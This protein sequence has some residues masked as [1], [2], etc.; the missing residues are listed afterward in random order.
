MPSREPGR[1]AIFFD[2]GNTL[3]HLDYEGIAATFREYGVAVT[4]AQVRLGEQRARVPIDGM[5][6]GTGGAQ[7][8]ERDILRAYFRFALEAVG[9]PFTAA[10][11]A[12]VEPLA[13]RVRE[14]RL[15][16]VVEPGTDALLADLA[17][18]GH[19]LGVVSNSNGT[20]ES[21]LEQVGLRRH[22][23]FV[24]DSAVVG[25]EKPHPRIFHLALERGGV[26]AAEAVY[27][28]DLYHVDVL[29][30]TGAGLGAVLLD[31]AGAWD[32]VTCPKAPDLLAAAAL[33]LRGAC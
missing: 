12:A 14:G 5:V 16:T 31:P 8:Q 27:I 19:L 1:K 13:R 33:I 18:R 6:A 20:V 22:F 4:A 23:A 10:A 15:W 28:G 3:L 2:A 29:G 17:R 30:A 26:R 32:G 7:R 24:I 11:E 9:L 25:V 21:C